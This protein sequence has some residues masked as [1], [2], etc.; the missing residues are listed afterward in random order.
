M[1]VQHPHLS[2]YLHQLTIFQAE[3]ASIQVRFSNRKSPFLWETDSNCS[4][5]SQ[6]NSKFAIKTLKRSLLSAA[7]YVHESPCLSFVNL[8]ASADVSTPFFTMTVIRSDFLCTNTTPF[9]SPSQT[10]TFPHRPR[11]LRRTP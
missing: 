1:C 7:T 11:R 8:P 3:T 5:N 10:N 6:G 2:P 9:F 4:V